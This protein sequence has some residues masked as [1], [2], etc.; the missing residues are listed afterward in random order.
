MN[1]PDDLDGIHNIDIVMEGN[2]YVLR[3]DKYERSWFYDRHDGK[4]WQR[5]FPGSYFN[6]RNDA[7]I[8]IINQIK[9]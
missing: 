3:G 8:C 6:T 4:W 2:K 5:T 1:V 7:Y 9:K